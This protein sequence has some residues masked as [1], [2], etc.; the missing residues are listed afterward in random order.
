VKNR[1]KP[2]SMRKLQMK[3]KLTQAGIKTTMCIQMVCGM[4]EWT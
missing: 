2:E 3:S 1:V 4:E